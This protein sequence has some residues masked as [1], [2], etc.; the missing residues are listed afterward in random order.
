MMLLTFALAIWDAQQ[1]CSSASI[2][3]KIGIYVI[4][5]LILFT[6]EFMV[7]TKPNYKNDDDDQTFKWSGL[8]FVEQIFAPVDSHFTNCIQAFKHS[9]RSSVV[10]III[11]MEL[12]INALLQ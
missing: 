5:A 11:V 12:G 1:Q 7:G 2:K 3:R 10:I 4:K 6:N 9:F 8:F